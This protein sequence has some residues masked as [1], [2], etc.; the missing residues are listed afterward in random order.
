MT[1]SLVVVVDLEIDHMAISFE[2]A[3]IVL[4]VGIIGVAEV[5]VDGDCLDDARNGFRAKRRDAR[6][7]YGTPS[8]KVLP[9]AIVKSANGIG[10]CSHGDL[11][12]ACRRWATRLLVW[13]ASPTAAVDDLIVGNVSWP[14]GRLARSALSASTR[15]RQLQGRH[16]S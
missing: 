9:Q 10:V 14:A 11:I 6:S 5:V 1:K 2:R 16:P 7:Y 15:R 13:H 4:L 12:D 3:E 8:A